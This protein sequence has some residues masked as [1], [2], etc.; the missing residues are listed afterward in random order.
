VLLVESQAE[1]GTRFRASVAIGSLEGVRL[2]DGGSIAEA[3]LPAP[4]TTAETRSPSEPE[5]PLQGLRLLLAEDGPDNQRLISHLLI[6]AGAQVTLTEDGK[7]AAEAALG[8][9]DA[10][11]PFNLIL[12]DM[13]MPVMDGYEATRL[14]RAK[15]YEGPI[16]AL[17]A[18]A[19]A[20]D[21]DKCIQAG[22]DDY[23]CKPINRKALI[24]TI[25]EHTS[26]QTSAVC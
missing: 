12:M 8:A 5:R 3:I 22:C 25:C 4:P 13:Q 18:H 2:I 9:W 6:K 19:M 14:L 16:I 26:A 7:Q 20:T 1:L 23:S 11:H 15:G 21:R 24:L 10:G 17:T